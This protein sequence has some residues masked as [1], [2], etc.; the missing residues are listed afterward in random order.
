MGIFCAVLLFLL[1]FLWPLCA[2]FTRFVLGLGDLCLG[3]SLLCS[4]LILL[5][6]CAPLWPS[7]TLYLL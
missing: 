7:P 6:V 1:F 2:C 3:S 4:H 5:A